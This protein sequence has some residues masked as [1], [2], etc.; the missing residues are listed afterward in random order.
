MQWFYADENDKQVPMEESELQSLVDS[1][2]IKRDTLIWNESLP[3]WVECGNF[4]PELFGDPVLPEAPP[5]MESPAEEPGSTGG[6]NHFKNEAASSA[7]PADAPPNLPATRPGSAN[8]AEGI[9][10]A[11]MICG[12]LGI[13]VNLCSLVTNGC[14]FPVALALSIAAIVCG[15]SGR[16][17]LRQRGLPIQNSM[18][19]AGIVTGWVGIGI[20]VTLI[21]ILFLVVGAA[22]GFGAFSN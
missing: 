1:G 5:P 22:A 9:G 6:T 10:I 13:V 3:D 18:L 19:T 21:I 11:A 4:K 15:Y 12:I 7:R 14:T 20:F 16:S 17:N 8:P 2:V